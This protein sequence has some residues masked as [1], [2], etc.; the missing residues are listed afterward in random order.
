MTDDLAAP[1]IAHA[2]WLAITTATD[3]LLAAFVPALSTTPRERLL[4]AISEQARHCAVRHLGQPL[5]PEQAAAVDVMV[6]GRLDVAL[7][8]AHRGRTRSGG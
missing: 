1:G 4:A 7:A 3:D 5:T 6:E 2:Q 8:R